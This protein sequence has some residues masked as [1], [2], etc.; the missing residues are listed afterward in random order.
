MEGIAWLAALFTLAAFGACALFIVI[1][2]RQS[3]SN[4]LAKRVA[5][6]ERAAAEQ[7]TLLAKALAELGQK[8]PSAPPADSPAAAVSAP[9]RD[10]SARAEPSPAHA[11]EVGTSMAVPAPSAP[12]AQ[13]S[14]VPQLAPAPGAPL[15][16]QRAT[17]DVP[18][19]VRELTPAAE[20]AADAPAPPPARTGVEWEQWFGIKGAALVGGAILALAGLL[21]V[22]YSIERGWLGPQMRCLLAA[23]AG[24]AALLG[25]S[26]LRRRGFLASSDALAG[27]GVTVLIGAAWAAYSLYELIPFTLAFLAMAATTASCGLLAVRRSSQ[28]IAWFGLVGGFAT[29][30]LLSLGASTPI[31]LFLYLLGLDLAV[32]ALLRRRAW[33]NLAVVAAVATQL[34]FA[35]WIALH[36]EPRDASFALLFLGGVALVFAAARGTEPASAASWVGSIAPFVFAAY[37]A[38]RSEFGAHV[39][40]IAAL[41]LVLTI[42]AA[43]LAQRQANAPMQT[44]AGVGAGATLITWLASNAHGASAAHEA[45][46]AALCLGLAHVASAELARRRAG[47]VWTADAAALAL[48][49]LA[50]ALLF[51]AARLHDAPLVPWLFSAVGLALGWLRLVRVGARALWS[52][53]AQITPFVVYSLWRSLGAGATAPWTVSWGDAAL[54]A[55][56]AAAAALVAWRA[57][58]S[59]ARRATALGVLVVCVLAL[60]ERSAVRADSDTTPG[61]LLA[62]VWSCALL[63]V[64][65]ARQAQAWFGYAVISAA[66]WLLTMHVLVLERFVPGGELALVVTTLV[67]GL[68]LAAAPT[69]V[70][71]FARPS[72]NA[73]RASA[74]V[75]LLW[76]FA[77]RRSWDE[78]AWGAGHELAALLY[79]LAGL[80][81]AARWSNQRVSPGEDG[82][83]SAASTGFV[84]MCVASAF[85]AA[86]T[87]DRLEAHT[88]WTLAAAVFVAATAWTA[89]AARHTGVRWIVVAAG[90]GT[91][92]AVL[93]VAAE[94]LRRGALLER[95]GWPVWHELS[96]LVGAPAIALFAAAWFTRESGKDLEAPRWSPV[97]WLSGALSLAAVLTTFLWLN[98]E[99]VNVLSDGAHY[100]F[101]WVRRPLRDVALSVAW[102]CYALTLL[103][104]G[105]RFD[106]SALR[107]T[108]PVFFLATIAKVFLYDLGELRGLHR[109]G[110]LVGLA[111]ALLSVSVLYQRLVFRARSP[112]TS[113]P[114]G[115]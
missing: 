19:V 51:G 73:L 91:C 9:E 72:R 45:A 20:H 75:L 52:V 98:I 61:A 21:F 13:L 83:R 113:P 35:L 8:S 92:I 12:L 53:A 110:S 7:R 71:Y 101:E 18:P 77:A 69:L 1:L 43:W 32:L 39:Y 97:P 84:W 58:D 24:V 115:R 36:F 105:M 54:V 5:A 49:P 88:Q 15:E 10:A 108:S 57:R 25:S 55:A 27:A 85:L 40:P 38:G 94:I 62:T 70:A 68:S 28:T 99:V 100:A 22:Q 42:A 14:A 4:D 93:S 103:V 23:A 60:L 112:A 63:G 104:V 33:S 16:H 11:A 78:S 29:P 102:T 48:A 17:L 6:L 89:G 81:L 46:F 3:R 76:E 47:Q 30:L 44:A 34:I 87:V 41:L 86:K 65:A 67:L 107:W 114:G 106:R 26:P 109:V 64:L 2:V 79:L 31:G 80:F 59:G 96:Y 37:F 82:A 111:L 66:A 95:T 56:L 90:A 50:A 74:L